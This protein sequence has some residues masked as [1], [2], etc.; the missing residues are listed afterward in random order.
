[1]LRLSAIVLLC[2]LVSPL[3]PAQQPASC[4]V[5]V[6]CPVCGPARVADPLTALREGNGRFV[7]A[8]PRHLHQTLECAKQLSCCQKPFA[9][10]LGCSDSRVPPDVL[11]DQGIG[12]LFVIRVAGNV[13]TPDALA[14]AEYAVDHLDAKLV[15]VMGHQRC[16]AVQAAFC[17]RPDPHLD[18]L[19][20][21]IR[22]SVAHPLPSCDHHEQVD[23]AQWD[24]SVKKNI[25]NMAAIVAKDLRGRASV[26][27][28]TAYY[29]LDDGRVEFSK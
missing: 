24:Q 27:V 22:P 18:V 28:V 15:V 7:K 14:S 12:D 6:T 17:P 16:G 5:G 21:L 3:A 19:W 4:P 25:T 20:D 9:V 26:S 11:F 29:N 8:D 13:A 10:V 2:W 1:M 23:P